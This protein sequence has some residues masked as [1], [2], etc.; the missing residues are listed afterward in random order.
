MVP[1]EFFHQQGTLHKFEVLAIEASMNQTIT[2]GEFI[3]L[4]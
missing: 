2:S 1:P 4:P 3:T